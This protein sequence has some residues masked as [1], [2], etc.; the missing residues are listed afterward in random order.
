MYYRDV[1]HKE[2]G[3]RLAEHRVEEVLRVLAAHDEEVLQEEELAT[4]VVEQR[5]LLR[6]EEHLEREL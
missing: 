3:E 4:T 6:A 1:T 2:H 5:E